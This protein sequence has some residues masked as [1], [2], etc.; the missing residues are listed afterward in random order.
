MINDPKVRIGLNESLFGLVAPPFVAEPY[1]LV[2]GHRLGERH[3]MRGTLHK[4]QAALEIGLVDELAE[5]GDDAVGKCVKQLEIAARANKKA[6]GVS[7]MRMRGDLIERMR[8]EAVDDT[9]E[10]MEYFKDET[11]QMLINGYLEAVRAKGKK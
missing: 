2:L 5:N 8:R 10:T 9:N 7:K 4:P 1:K 6:Y 11:F 3:L